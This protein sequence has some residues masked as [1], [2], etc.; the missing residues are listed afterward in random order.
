MFA[1]NTFPS[2]LFPGLTGMS[3]GHL[4]SVTAYGVKFRNATF[5]SRNEAKI[6]LGEYL[7]RKDIQ[8]K[9]KWRDGHCT[10]YVCDNGIKFFI[11]RA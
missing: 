10:T 3:G 7:D 8:V 11:S 9:E 1:T 2:I 5:G 4:Y 6:Y